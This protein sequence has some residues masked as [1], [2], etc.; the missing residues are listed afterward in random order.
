MQ[1][2]LMLLQPFFALRHGAA[3][4]AILREGIS[5]LTGP[6]IRFQR[7]PYL[8]PAATSRLPS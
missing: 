1:L 2:R 6:F 4:F 7:A 3:E 8:L 5:Q